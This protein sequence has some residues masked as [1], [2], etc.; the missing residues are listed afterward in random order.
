[1]L[2]M[3][4]ICGN[5]RMIHSASESGFSLLEVLLAIT[6]LSVGMLGTGVLSLG[7]VTS[8]KVSRDVTVATALAQDKMEEVRKTGYSG[9]A[10]IDATVTEDYGSIVV[11]VGGHTADF[12]AYRRVTQTQVDT[13]AVGMKT[14]S[15]S[16]FHRTGQGSVALST[17]VAD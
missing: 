4:K 1:M 17:I 2:V 10:S 11:S 16:V 8:N 9:L 6:I 14:V 7:V 3:S 13:P 5:N 12:S 15:V